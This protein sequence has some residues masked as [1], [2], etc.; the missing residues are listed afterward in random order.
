MHLPANFQGKMACFFYRKWSVG[1]I[2]LLC[3]LLEGSAHGQGT[4]LFNMQKIEVAQKR[5][6]TAGQTDKSGYVKSN[7]TILVL[8]KTPLTDLFIPKWQATDLPFFCKIEHKMGKRTPLP[9]KFRL[10]SVQYVD[11]LEGK[12]QWMPGDY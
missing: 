1:L 9:V 4:A 2:I 12:T 10:G 7:F 6:Q 5:L 8:H 11:F 3:F